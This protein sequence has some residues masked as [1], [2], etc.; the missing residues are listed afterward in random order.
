MEVLQ[1]D[2]K[3]SVK[4]DPSNND[5]PYQW[6]RYGEVHGPFAEN[7]ATTSLFYALLASRQAV[8]A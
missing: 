1:I 6:L 2:D 5:R 3:W 7:N 8:T 4:Y